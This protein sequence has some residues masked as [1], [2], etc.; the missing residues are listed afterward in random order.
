MCSGVLGSSSLQVGETHGWPRCRL[1]DRLRVP[2]VV[3][4]RFYIGLNIFWRHQPDPMLLVGENPAQM[5]RAVARLHCY[6]ARGQSLDESR[7]PFSFHPATQ[8]DL[9][10]FVEARQAANVLTKVDFKNSYF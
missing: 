10:R 9:P 1:G 4:L 7:E 8:D 5:M 6:D 3:F 2:V